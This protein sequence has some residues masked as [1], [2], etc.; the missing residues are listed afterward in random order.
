MYYHNEKETLLYLV[1]T[2]F[3][4]FYYVVKGELHSKSTKII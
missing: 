1:L 4:P 3:K 2:S